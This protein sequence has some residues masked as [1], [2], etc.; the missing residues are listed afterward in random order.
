VPLGSALPV[1]TFFTINQGHAFGA[2]GCPARL[3]SC[4]GRGA[5]ARG[6]A[7][8]EQRVLRR[9]RLGSRGVSRSWGGSLA[10]R[11]SVGTHGAGRCR[12]AVIRHPRPGPVTR[13]HASCW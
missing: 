5:R 13:R 8:D 9:W 7:L 6:V 12:R 11:L 1:Q 10:R 2:P 3:G 4:S